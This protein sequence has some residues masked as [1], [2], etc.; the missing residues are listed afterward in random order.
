MNLETIFSAASSLALLGWLGLAAG[1]AWRLD[2]LTSA[3]GLLIPGVLALGYAVLLAMTL[4]A[5]D[6]GFDSLDAVRR[7]F[8]NPWVLLAGWIHY[9]CFD[10]LTGHWIATETR[11]LGLPRWLL[12]PA[13]PLTF[14]FGPLGLLVFFAG[15]ASLPR[16][17]ALA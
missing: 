8:A 16:R 2:R 10:L 11:R 12:I 9:L 17:A 14:L 7:L 4:P 15:A 5:S 3:V 6:G 1:A 13:L